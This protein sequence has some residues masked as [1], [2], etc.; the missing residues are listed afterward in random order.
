MPKETKGLKVADVEIPISIPQTSLKLGR[1]KKRTSTPNQKWSISQMYIQQLDQLS[2]CTCNVRK[3]SKD[4]HGYVLQVHFF[5]L[6]KTKFLVSHIQFLSMRWKPSIDFPW[7]WGLLKR[8]GKKSWGRILY[9]NTP[10]AS[11][12]VNYLMVLS[13]KMGTRI[14]PSNRIQ[15]N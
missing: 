12:W 6:I 13:C 4:T 14:S 5:F 8:N 10:H 11:Q 1:K 2:V 9:L 15:M 3:C 7:I